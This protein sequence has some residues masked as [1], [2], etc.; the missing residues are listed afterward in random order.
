MADF[1]IMGLRL[2]REGI[3]RH[4]FASRFGLDL[5]DIFQM[6][7][8]ELVRLGLLEWAAATDDLVISESSAAP[9]AER[10]ILRLTKRGRLLGNRVFR[11]FVATPAHDAAP[12]RAS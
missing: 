2:T 4:R 7:I 10:D 6:Q 9:E 8:A 12:A 11:E 1:M 5:R 3:S